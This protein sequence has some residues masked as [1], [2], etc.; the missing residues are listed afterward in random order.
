MGL[1]LACRHLNR[2]GMDKVYGVQVEI[3]G[4]EHN[5][6][7]IDSPSEAFTCCLDTGFARTTTGNKI[8]AS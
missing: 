7:S 1:V 3:T 6:E 5:V 8:L 4:D 2:F